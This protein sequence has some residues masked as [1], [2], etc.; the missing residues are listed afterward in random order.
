MCDMHKR[1][2]RTLESVV[3]LLKEKCPQENWEYKFDP[4]DFE[5]D[6]VLRS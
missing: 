1:F 4:K 5:G 3:P 6:E 2:V